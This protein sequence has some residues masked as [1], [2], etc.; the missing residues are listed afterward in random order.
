MRNY[1]PKE[2]RRYIPKY[3]AM[4]YVMNYAQTHGLKPFYKRPVE[5]LATA[6]VHDYM[7][8]KRLSTMTGI[9]MATIKR[10]NPA[11]LKNYIPKN[12]TKGYMLTLPEQ[13]MYLFLSTQDDFSRLVYT[14]DPTQD[15]L[16]KTYLYGSMRQK[17]LQIANLEELETVHELRLK[18][19]GPLPYLPDN[20]PVEDN[21][22][23]NDYAAL[24]NER[25]YTYHKLDAQQSL[26]DVAE[27]FS[28]ALEDLI[29]WNN[30]DIDNPPP[31]GSVIR[32][33]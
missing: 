8:F 19:D 12:S 23:E 22:R 18:I 13:A 21:N 6:V 31:P 32:I 16:F 7:T 25:S 14:S 26:L 9:D 20:D 15:Q 11:F 28:V 1:F 17:R 2:T 24:L 27:L 30:L 10:L 5:A 33:D 4:S 3:V 29:T